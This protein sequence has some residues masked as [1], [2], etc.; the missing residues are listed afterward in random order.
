MS[1]TIR[2]RVPMAEY[3]AMPGLS[4]SRLKELKHSPL[5]Y[6]YRLEH[7]LEK[8]PLTLG[9]AAHCA[10][11]EPERFGKQFAVWSKRTEGG[12]LAPRTGA[13]WAAFAQ[14][15]NGRD[16]LTD[17]EAGLA[18][19]IATAVRNNAVAM[20]YLGEG[21]PEVTLQWSLASESMLRQPVEIAAKGRPDWLTRIEGQRVL[22]GLKSARDVRPYFFGSA[23]ARLS[24]HLHWA[25]YLDGYE[26]ITGERP[27]MR[28][29][30]VESAP[31]HDVVVYEIPDDVIEQGRADYQALLRELLEREQT[32]EWPGV[33]GGVEQV[34][35]LPTW[36]YPQA[37]DD[38]SD[39]GLE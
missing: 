20:K 36:A 2:S 11:L 24:Y 14:E 27:L 25:Y 23:A 6:R 13:A 8:P 12:R 35:T 1:G 26:A 33:G 34:L 39:L 10:T 18:Q 17:T 21:E 7:P 4:L 3:R 5:H 38:I 28:E 22:V 37:S 30:V 19:A 15:N 16:I 29:I 31:P 32:K 9:T